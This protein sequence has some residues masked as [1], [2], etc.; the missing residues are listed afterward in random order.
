VALELASDERTKRHDA[1]SFAARIGNEPLDQR[2]TDAGSLQA[3]VNAGVVSNDLG[4]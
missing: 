3:I 4:R 2:F 1:E